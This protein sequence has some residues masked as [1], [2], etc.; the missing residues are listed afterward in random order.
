M[1]I[2]RG[3]GGGAAI[4]IH[5]SHCLEP[6]QPFPSLSS[7]LSGDLPARRDVRILGPYTHD[8]PRTALGGG[9]L[10]GAAGKSSLVILG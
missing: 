5:Q 7:L 1:L 2:G 6:T 3:W 4:S 8:S 9:G 10:C